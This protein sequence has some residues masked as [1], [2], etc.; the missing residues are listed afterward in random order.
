[1]IA[2][3]ENDN[4]VG[5]NAQQDSEL[6]SSQN[7]SERSWKKPMHLAGASLAKM[8]CKAKLILGG[9]ITLIIT[10]IILIICIAV[11]KSKGTYTASKMIDLLSTMPNL[12]KYSLD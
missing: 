7:T 3:E 11:A 9:I 5:L 2:E 4:K 1:M 12:E 8:S 10:M 6:G